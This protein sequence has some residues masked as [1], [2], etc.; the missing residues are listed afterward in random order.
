MSRVSSLA[1]KPATNGVLHEPDPPKASPTTV[2]EHVLSRLREIG[3]SAIF[4]VPGDYAFAVEDAIVNFPASFDDPDGNSRILQEI[5]ARLPGLVDPG[6]TSFGSI[7]ERKLARLVCGLHGGGG[8]RGE[9]AEVT[10]LNT[11]KL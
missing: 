10:D 5:T 2:I 7:S 9:A 6:A 1:A 4:G 8:K 3:I 11:K